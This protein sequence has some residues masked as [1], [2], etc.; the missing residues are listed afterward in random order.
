MPPL[1]GTGLVADDFFLLA[2][3][4]VTG[5]PRL[6]P[7]VTGIGLAGALLTELTL[8]G[9]TD[10]RAGTLVVLDDRRPTD[11][12]LAG[13]LGRVRTERR[14]HQVGAWLSFLSPG[15]AEEVAQRAAG[16]G[17]LV[18]VAQ[19]GLRRGV[20]WAPADRSTAAW[21]AARLRM[22]LT[23]TE[24]MAVGDVSLAGLARACGLAELVLA[25]AP[26]PARQHLDHL[27]STLA[28]PL[29]QLVAETETAVGNAVLAR[30]V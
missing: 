21:P 3:D 19:R 11:P 28:E 25:D 22:L 10:V 16:N 27:V 9:R 23:R 12:L 29:R 17:L 24:P 13:L 14:P 20:R 5:R 15:V 8:L 18:R 30:G 6:H 1:P 26:V 2:H 4:G 7:R